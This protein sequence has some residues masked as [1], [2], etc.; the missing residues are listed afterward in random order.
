MDLKAIITFFKKHFFGS[1]SPKYT[2]KKTK[3]TA[4]IYSFFKESIYIRINTIVHYFSACQ[5]APSDKI[6]DI[7][8]LRGVHHSEILDIPESNK[9]TSLF[10]KVLRKNQVTMD[11]EL[12]IFVPAKKK[13]PDDPFND[14]GV[15]FFSFFAPPE[16]FNY[17]HVFS[18]L[19][20]Q[21]AIELLT[22]LNEKLRKDV[23][24]PCFDIYSLFAILETSNI[25]PSAVNSMDQYSVEPTIYLLL[26]DIID[27]N[28]NMDVNGDKDNKKATII[29]FPQKK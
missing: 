28:H 21:Q 11:V 12:A 16:Y 17:L 25:M 10:V 1:S 27:K 22:L 15:E 2:L 29:N 18:K 24:S 8:F 23:V 14:E 7:S 26:G 3:K 19:T 4:T 5:L 13:Y 20:V 6:V 9:S